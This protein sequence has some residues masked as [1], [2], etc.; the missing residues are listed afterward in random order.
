MRQGTLGAA[1]LE[2]HEDLEVKGESYRQENLWC[3]VG[4]RHRPEARVR[5]DVYAMLL[6]EDGN[7]YDPNAVS[8]WIDGLMVGYL[9]KDQAPTLRPGLIAAQEREGKPIALEGVV[10]GGGMRDDGPGMLGV[11]LRYDP[12]D[13]GL[14]VPPPVPR[15]ASPGQ[16]GV[17]GAM[18][19]GLTEA[20][21]TDADDDSYDLSW[22][23]ELPEAD[24]PAI[25]KLRQLLAATRDPIDRH[26]QFTELEGRLYRSRDLYESA[27]T[28]Y[29]EACIQ[30]DADM[31]GICR[32]F[33]AKWGNIPL[34]ETYRQMAIRQA[35]KKDW[36]ACRWWAERGLALYGHSAAREEA[37]EDL[38]KRRNRA[39]AKLETTVVP[40]PRVSPPESLRV[41]APD[42]WP[43]RPSNP[44]RPDTELEVLVCHQCGSSFE[45]MRA[46]GRKPL[47][48]TQCRTWTST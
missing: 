32:A 33:M 15:P 16:R 48:C 46:R 12:E 17:E 39:V 35:K 21:L 45:R 28:E 6:A 37:V 10:V 22:Y 20:W 38:T 11:F 14:H 19:T 42:A 26:F 24:R 4:G 36:S 5:K 1:L 40:T 23:N 18:R 30:H 27:L 25:A 34:L 41:V 31:E 7:P 8:V 2:G 3:V 9:P 13:F 47:L 29:D 44:V 43:R